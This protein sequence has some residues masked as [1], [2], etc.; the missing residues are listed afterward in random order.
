MRPPRILGWGIFLIL[1]LRAAESG[2]V[3]SGHAS[4][5]GTT[6]LF[7]VPTAEVTPEGSFRVGYQFIDDDWAYVERDSGENEIYF[8]TAG[9]LPRL[10]VSIRATVFTETDFVLAGQR[11]AADRAL[12]ARLQILHEGRWP[13]VAVGIDDVR[14]TR[15]THALYGVAT[16]TIGKS[17]QIFQL[18]ASAGFGSRAIDAAMYLLDGAFGGLECGFLR[19]ATL[20]LEYDTEKWNTGARV[21]VLP[22]VTVQ[23]VLFDLNTVSG[24][25]SW[26]RSF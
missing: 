10:E 4:L 21:V 12:S 23:G 7:N 2:A 9:F 14:G 18:M 24:G 8:F 3:G 19:R 20:V 16:K 1:V 26:T 25:V 15:R 11:D 6:G 17:D 13:A 5:L 22:G